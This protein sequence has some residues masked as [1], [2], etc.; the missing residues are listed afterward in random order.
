MEPLLH[1]ESGLASFGTKVAQ[2]LNGVDPS[3][4]TQLLD[5]TCRAKCS[6]ILNDIKNTKIRGECLKSSL[7]AKF[8]SSKKNSMNS[9]PILTKVLYYQLTKAFGICLWLKINESIFWRH[10]GV[11][12]SFFSFLFYLKIPAKRQANQVPYSQLSIFFVT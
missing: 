2:S 8:I 7:L 11:F 10:F 1:K 6:N 3:L 5:D 4:R 12:C 9:H